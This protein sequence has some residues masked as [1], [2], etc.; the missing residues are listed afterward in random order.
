M[1]EPTVPKL[2]EDPVSISLTVSTQR[3][4]LG[5]AD[6]IRVAIRNNLAQAVRLTFDN[7]CQVF[8]T[9]RDQEGDVVTPR[10][11]RPGC[12]AVPTQLILQP[13][14]PSVVT[15]I[16]TGGFDFSPPDTPDKVPPGSYFVSAQLVARGYSTLAP[17][18]KVDVVP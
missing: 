16:W 15:T 4:Q 3:L 2:Q 10:D 8:V 18:F 9:I 1:S 7:V 5:K 13:T 14:T 17:A 12:L 11:G 6:T